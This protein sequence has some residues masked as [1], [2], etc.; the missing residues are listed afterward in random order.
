MKLLAD[1]RHV[2]SL[3]IYFDKTTASARRFQ[4]LKC[5]LRNLKLPINLIK[6]DQKTVYIYSQVSVYY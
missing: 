5:V 3:W 1:F 4:T 6:S 2:V